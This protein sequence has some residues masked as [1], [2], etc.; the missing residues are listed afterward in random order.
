MSVDEPKPNVCVL[1]ADGFEEIEA[2][3][4][5]DVLRRAELA[6]TTLGVSGSE[7]TGSHGITVRADAR[8]SAA[9]GRHWDAVVLPGGMPGAATLRDDP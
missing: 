8:L 1:L 2:I 5:I 7:V 9:A 6:V 4:L 3:T